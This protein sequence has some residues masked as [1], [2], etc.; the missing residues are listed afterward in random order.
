MLARRHVSW[1]QRVTAYIISPHFQL[2]T[3]LAACLLLVSLPT[4]LL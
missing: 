4:F 3:Q 2:G 1:I